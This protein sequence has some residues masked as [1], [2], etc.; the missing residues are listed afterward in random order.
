MTKIVNWI[1][2]VHC[3]RSKKGNKNNNK[4]YRNITHVIWTHKIED[5]I[6]SSPW[7]ILASAKNQIF[8]SLFVY[9]PL[10]SWITYLLISLSFVHSFVQF[11]TFPI[12]KM[13]NFTVSPLSLRRNIVFNWN[14][15]PYSK[16][17]F[18]I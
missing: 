15:I 17:T 10:T 16:P 4:T 1:K 11:F 12:L 6:Y 8:C 13:P 7:K 2:E 3:T 14:K 5:Q 9:L 18:S